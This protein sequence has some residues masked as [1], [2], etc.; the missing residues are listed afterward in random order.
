MRKIILIA[1][2]GLTQFINAQNAPTCSEAYSLCSS[3]GVPFPNAYGTLPG[4]GTGGSGSTPAMGCLGT[5]PNPAWF[6]LPISQDGNLTFNIS[7]VSTTGVGIDVDFICFGPFNSL[8]EGCNSLVPEYTVDCSYSASGV[9]QLS[10][11]N[12]QAG[13]I[14]LL[15][16]TNFNGA[17][18]FITINDTS[19]STGV[20]GC[21]G[22]NLNAFID[23]NGNGVQDTGE[24]GFPFGTYTYEVNDSGTV[25]NISDADGNFTIYDESITNSYDI[26]YVIPEIYSEYYSVAPASI[27]D[28]TPEVA[29]SVDT[30]N[31]P[32][33]VLQEYND[34]SVQLIASAGNPAAGFNHYVTIV[35]TNLGT[36][37]VASGTVTFTQDNAFTVIGIY[38]TGGTITTSGCV[39][40]FT[41]LAPL[42]TRYITVYMTVPAI[43]EVALGQITSCTASI[44]P[45][46]DDVTPADNSSELTQEI[47]ASY[48]PND[49]TEAHGPRI[50]ADDFS[51]DEYLYYTIRFQNTGTASAYNIRVEELLNEQ[52]DPSTLVMLHGSHDFTLDRTGNH[53]TWKFANI[54]LPAEQVNEEGSHGYVTFKIKPYPG[55]QAGDVI[56]AA[57][58]IYFDF[59][60]VIDTPP[61]DTAFVSE[62]GT[63]HLD[64]SSFSLYPNPV[65]ATLNIASVKNGIAAVRLYDLTGKTLLQKTFSNP[66]Q[67]TI[68][69]A[70]LAQGS[71]FIAITDALGNSTVKK[72]MK[73]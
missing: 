52:V 66:M 5:T 69:T 36:Q 38:P 16:V 67:A 27:S 61:Y 13:K 68:D 8:A 18:G 45:V 4:T 70:P 43:P 25:H 44:T 41:N 47:V 51:D 54:M 40:P 6:Y 31:F 30:Y 59:N 11:T 56:P 33:T 64:K 50:I 73:N 34:L 65:N 57:A 58:G 29:G 17:N 39:Y 71:Y 63:A 72:I 19:T 37:T 12:A 35:Y 22:I 55:I 23:N 7:Q 2:F 46:A 53:L 24:N 49:I 20:L 3:L 42:E 60:P 10:I 9:E 1:L 32:I 48:D 28:I 26:S 21:A 14:Y 62:L 15:M